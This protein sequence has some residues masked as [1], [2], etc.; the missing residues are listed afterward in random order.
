[1]LWQRPMEKIPVI[2]FTADG[3]FTDNGAIKALYHV[4]DD[5]SNPALAPGSG[6]YE[7]RD[8][9]ILFSFADGRKVKIAFLGSGYDIK[10]RSPLSMTMGFNEDEM[11]RR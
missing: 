1:M 5:C 6:V 3:K 8:H 11:R 2:T 9:S 7:V 4:S 10:N